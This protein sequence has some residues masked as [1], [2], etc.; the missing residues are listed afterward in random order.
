ME[1]V[2]IIMSF[3]FLGHLSE[4]EKKSGAREADELIQKIG[5][6]VEVQTG[7]ALFKCPM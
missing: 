4:T 6:T 1:V 2:S 7:P 3:N 5:W